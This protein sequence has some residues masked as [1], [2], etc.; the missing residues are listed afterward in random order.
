MFS[1]AKVSLERLFLRLGE[2]RLL[3]G[4]PE[5]PCSRCLGDCLKPVYGLFGACYI[6]CFG[7]YCGE[8]CGHTIC[9]NCLDY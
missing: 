5:S 1:Y 3:L 8:F 9:H 4:E 2:G 7:G 6:A